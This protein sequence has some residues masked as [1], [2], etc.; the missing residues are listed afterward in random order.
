MKFEVVTPELQEKVKACKT[1]KEL[2][3]LAKEEG[4]EL[5]DDE[6]AQIAGGG[7]LDGSWDIGFPLT[8]YCPHCHAMITGHGRKGDIVE[9]P[10]CHK[11]FEFGYWD[12]QK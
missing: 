12:D 9:C 1:P 4:R 3:A 6:I 2:L 8:F 11:T 5:S 10:V 7:D